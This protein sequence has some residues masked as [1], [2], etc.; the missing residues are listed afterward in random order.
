MRLSTVAIIQGGTHHSVSHMKEHEVQSISYIM[1]SLA[2]F[3]KQ[4][5]IIFQELKII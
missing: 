1:D 3:T 5:N 4:K 2:S